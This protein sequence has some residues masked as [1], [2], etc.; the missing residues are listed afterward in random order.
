MRRYLDTGTLPTERLDDTNKIPKSDEGRPAVQAVLAV[1]PDREEQ[2]CRGTAN[3]AVRSNGRGGLVETGDGSA[4][5]AVISVA[6]LFGWG[7]DQEN[8]QDY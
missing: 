2:R 7:H 3:T 6:S 5:E 8:N 4:P 1:P